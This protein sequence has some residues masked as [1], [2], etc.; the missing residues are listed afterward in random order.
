[1][2]FLNGYLREIEYEKKVS[3]LI[4]TP[5]N[6]VVEGCLVGCVFLLFFLAIACKQF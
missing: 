2:G 1:M 5:K 4:Y 6:R 3:E